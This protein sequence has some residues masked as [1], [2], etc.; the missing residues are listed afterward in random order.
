[1]KYQSSYNNLRECSLS[2][3]NYS[4]GFNDVNGEVWQVWDR[5]NRQSLRSTQDKTKKQSHLKNKV[6]TKKFILQNQNSSSYWKKS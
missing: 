5:E 4:G 3:M 1:M 2:N 6:T